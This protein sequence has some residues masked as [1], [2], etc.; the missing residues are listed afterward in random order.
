VKQKTDKYTSP[1]MQNETVKV[2]ALRILRKISFNLQSKSFYSMML[3]ETTD[4]NVEQV[5]VCLIRDI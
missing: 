1:E 5:V 4:V 2:M 3:D